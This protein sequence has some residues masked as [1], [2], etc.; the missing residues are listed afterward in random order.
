MSARM[1]RGTRQSALMS[2]LSIRGVEEAVL[3]ARNAYGEYGSVGF[4]SPGS[5]RCSLA[6]GR[7]AIPRLCSVCAPACWRSPL[8]E[9]PI[10][11]AIGGKVS[12]WE[13]VRVLNARIKR[14]GR[15]RRRCGR[16]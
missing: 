8:F 15:S 4:D 10:Q 11:W 16:T 12:A 9:M 6:H 7:G 5:V 14:R 3:M 2:R 13:S 1:V